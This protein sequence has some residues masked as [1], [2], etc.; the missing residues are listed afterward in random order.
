MLIIISCLLV[1]GNLLGTIYFFMIN[2]LRDGFIEF[3]IFLIL[4]SS[5]CAMCRYSVE[6]KGNNLNK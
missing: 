3:F 2:D 5:T 1:I 6:N 4:L